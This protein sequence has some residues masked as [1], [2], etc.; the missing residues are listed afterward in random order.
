MC[1]CV[2]VCVYVYERGREGERE[3]DTEKERETEKEEREK[4]RKREKECVYTLSSCTVPSTRAHSRAYWADTQIRSTFV[5]GKNSRANPV[6]WHGTT[7]TLRHAA[8]HC[9]KRVLS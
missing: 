9:N 1:V 6:T 2:C 5:V 7:N 3:R 8:T 4:K